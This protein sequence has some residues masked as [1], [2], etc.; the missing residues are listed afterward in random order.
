ME[1][2]LEYEPIEYVMDDLFAARQ[3]WSRVD[4]LVTPRVMAECGIDDALDAYNVIKE[5]E[6]EHILSVAFTEAFGE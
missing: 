6:R 3:R 5:G 1:S 2:E 4:Y